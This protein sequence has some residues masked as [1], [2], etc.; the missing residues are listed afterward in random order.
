MAE[1]QRARLTEHSYA[2]KSAPHR[3]MPVGAAAQYE[4]LIEAGYLVA[5]SP[6][7]VT[8]LIKDQEQRLGVGRFLTYLPFG[9]MEPPQAMKSLELFAREV[10]PNLR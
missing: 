7:T 10:L 8:R 9:T 1:M 5:G 2:Y 4:E 6:D 3:N